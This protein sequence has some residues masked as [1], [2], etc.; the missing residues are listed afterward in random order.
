MIILPAIDLMDGLCVRLIRGDPT[1]RKVYGDPVE[2]AK[3]FED[4][5]A[6]WIP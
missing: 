5:G 3:K 4:E 1:K 6:Q 2:I